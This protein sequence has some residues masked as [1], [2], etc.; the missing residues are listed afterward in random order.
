MAPRSRCIL[1]RAV[2]SLICCCPALVE[3]AEDD[4]RGIGNSWI[5]GGA[6]EGACASEVS[7]AVRTCL[8]KSEGTGGVAAVSRRAV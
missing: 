6:E 2:A 5:V 4:E 3:L 8:R 1:A 7:E